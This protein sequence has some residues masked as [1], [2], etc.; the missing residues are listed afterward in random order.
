VSDGTIEA[1][2]AGDRAEFD[3]RQKIS[4]QAGQYTLIIPGSDGTA[5]LP[6]GDSYATVT[7]DKA[8][9]VKLAG[10]LADG[11][12]LT[13]S[14][15][16]SKHGEWPFFVS[17]Y[18]G[19]GVIVSWVTFQTTLTNDLS[20]DLVWIKPPLA[21]AKFYPGG[22][23]LTTSA[24]GFGYHMPATG[25]SLFNFTNATFVLF[26][27]DLAQPITNRVAIGANNRVMNLSSNKLTLTFKTSTGLFSG[28]VV[29]PATAKSLTFNGVVLPEAELG[30][31]YFLGTSQTGEA[32][33]EPQ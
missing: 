4:P 13:Q 26:G 21:T 16:V 9:K 20:G 18:G 14:A 23:N 28:H 30:L 15:I 12:K 25:S 22:F 6:G 3:G 17:L 1:S 19:K 5:L 32:I 33:L 10:S 8:G 2:L 7:V 29:N 27:G 24:L 11:T 31:G